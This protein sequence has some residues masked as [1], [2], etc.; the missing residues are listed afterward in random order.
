LNPDSVKEK[1][2]LKDKLITQSSSDIRRK[3]QKLPQ[4]PDDNLEDLL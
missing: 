2:I 4:G 3:L 1:L